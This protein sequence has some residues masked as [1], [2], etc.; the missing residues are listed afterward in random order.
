MRAARGPAR[1]GGALLAV[2][3]LSVALTA[4]AFAL[5]RGV[6]TEFDRASLR[7]DSLKAYYLAQGAIEATMRRIARPRDPENPERGFEA[8]Q[9]F[10][11][12][13][14]A[15]GR[16]EV[17]IVGESGKLD[18][19]R[20]SPGA[21]A[22]LLAHSGVEPGE[23]VGIAA[24]IV[25]YREQ[26]RRGELAYGLDR[27]EALAAFDLDSGS[28][29]RIRQTSIQELE[30]LLTIPGVTAA[31]FYGSYRETPAGKLVRMGGLAENLTTRGG[32]AVNVNYASPE[33]LL[34]AG[35]PEAF[36]A[37][38]V[39]ARR[40]RPLRAGDPGMADLAG[41]GGEIRLGATGG[42]L[43]YTLRATAELG[44]GRARRTVAAMVEQGVT[45][46]GPD[47]IRIVRW[48]GTSF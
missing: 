23:A 13:V 22:R 30:E 35:V 26:L 19:N 45:G 33:L 39:A 6:R 38:I 27:D 29:F 7:I 9:R 34:A 42:S 48:Y 37:E 14:F 41:M 25:Q 4:I 32:A 46:E 2:L 21:L 12:F 43:A 18:V 20:A 1:R 36:V 8:G 47:P 44:E 3:W 24:R 40:L 28:S 11:Q 15:S 31:M 16:A 17:E 10:M 5:S